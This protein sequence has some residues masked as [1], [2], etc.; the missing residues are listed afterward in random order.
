MQQHAKTNNLYQ[1]YAQVQ[2]LVSITHMHKKMKIK[3][4]SGKMQEHVD[5]PRFIWIDKTNPIYIP[6]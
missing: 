3:N 4:K 1:F 5:Y 2:E 6:S